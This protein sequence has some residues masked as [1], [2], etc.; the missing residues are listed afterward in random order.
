[1]LV[2]LLYLLNNDIY[3]V[4]VYLRFVFLYWIYILHSYHDNSVHIHV[5][6]YL[7]RLH[8]FRS[9][10]YSTRNKLS[11]VE[12]RRRFDFYEQLAHRVVLRR[13]S[14]EVVLSPVKWYSQRW[15]R[16]RLPAGPVRYP[17]GFQ[18]GRYAGRPVRS[19]RLRPVPVV[20][21]PDRFHLWIQYHTVHF[22]RY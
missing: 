20:K 13:E 9:N 16:Y 7:N 19:E 8:G 3:L 22:G 2:K 15:N 11:I 18:T 14:P 4:N 5:L 6:V 1:M 10:G 12:M 17:S 21:N